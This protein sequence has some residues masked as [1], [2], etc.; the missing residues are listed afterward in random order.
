MD[1]VY[2]VCAVVGGTIFVCQF[3]LSV[4]GFG[5]DHDVGGHD[6]DLHDVGGDDAGGAHGAVGHEAHS[7]WFVGVF[8]FRTV[9]AALTFF[10]FGGLAAVSSQVPPLT[11][12]GIAVAAGGSALY[13]VAWM[14]RTLHDLK[15]DGTAQIQSALG[16]V[17]TVYLPIPGKNSG[18]GKVTVTVQERTMEYQAL[19]AGAELATGTT[20]TVV[21]ILD[22][23]TV[24]VAPASL[25]ER[26]THA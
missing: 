3:A 21:S 16:Q 15:D 2:F 4:F 22:S 20:V 18:L 24:E 7:N 23:D 25:P 12:F 8:T 6:G 13:A 14:M 10:G 26:T 19:T 17:A 5:G 1:Q 11:A 9:L